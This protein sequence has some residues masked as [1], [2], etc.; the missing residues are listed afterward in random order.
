MEQPD[1]SHHAR[2]EA[3]VDSI[4]PDEDLNQNGKVYVTFVVSKDGQITNIK[5]SKS[6]YFERLDEA[7]IKI[8]ADI[9]NIEAIPKELNKHSWEITVPIVYQI[10]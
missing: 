1:L 9:G 7:A 5:V 8:L 10:K 4:F 6:S 2:K 3:G